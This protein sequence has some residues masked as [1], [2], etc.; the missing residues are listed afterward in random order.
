MGIQTSNVLDG[1]FETQ[2]N[3]ARISVTGSGTSLDLVELGLATNPNGNDIQWET[4]TLDTIHSFSSSGTW[5][6]W[7]ITGTSYVITDIQI[8]IN[9]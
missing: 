3:T 4:V 6:Y 8:E 2:I 7:R 9:V 5:I 1:D